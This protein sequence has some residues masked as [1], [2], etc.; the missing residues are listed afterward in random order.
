MLLSHVEDIWDPMALLNFERKAVYDALRHAGYPVDIITEEDI[1]EGRL[2]P[3][4]ALYVF[5]QHL[6]DKTLNVVDQWV[7]D[8]GVLVATGGGGLSDQFD[9][10]SEKAHALYGARLLSTEQIPKKALETKLDLP[11]LKPLE[12]ITFHLPG[13]AKSRAI[14]ALAFCQHLAADSAE[15]LA[16]SS[17]PMPPPL[18]W[19]A[20]AR[21]RPSSLPA[22][23]VRPTS[24]RP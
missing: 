8:G 21:G 4:Q 6:E 22:S 1:Q 16:A 24:S 14:P 10:P 5:G 7:K 17:A 12:E 13:E 15:V 19:P 2:K 18:P 20:M 9:Q 11:R 23:L 3:Y